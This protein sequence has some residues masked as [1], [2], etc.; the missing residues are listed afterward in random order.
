M[1]RSNLSQP[2]CELVRLIRCTKS[3]SV[4]SEVRFEGDDYAAIDRRSVDPSNQCADICDR[5]CSIRQQRTRTL[6]GG[7]AIRNAGCTLRRK[8]KARSGICQKRRRKD[9]TGIDL[10]VDRHRRIGDCASE[11]STG[12]AL[13]SLHAVPEGMRVGP[14]PAARPGAARDRL[15]WPLNFPGGIPN[16]RLN[17]RLND[18]SES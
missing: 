15:N 17:A 1:K 12:V 13:D 7:K 14:L 10:L 11:V 16:S 9:A 4:P 2:A 5:R 3:T 8:A 18:A 6:R